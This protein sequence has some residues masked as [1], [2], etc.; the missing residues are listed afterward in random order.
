MDDD[1]A[2]V[3]DAH[4]PEI[5]DSLFEGQ[6]SRYERRFVHE[7]LHSKQLQQHPQGGSE[8]YASKLCQ[9]FVKY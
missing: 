8:T 7:T 1:R 9:N 2:L 3:V 6:L 5:S 4:V